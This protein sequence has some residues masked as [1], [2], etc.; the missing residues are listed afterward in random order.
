MRVSSTSECLSF[1]E[2][3]ALL[4]TSY[5]GCAIAQAVSRWLPTA[6]ARVRARVW[7]CGICGGQ[8]GT[9][10]GLLRVLRFPLPIFIPPIAPQSPSSI[11]WVLYNRPEVATV[12]S[13]LSPT[14]LI[15]FIQ[16][17]SQNFLSRLSPYADEIIGDHEGGFWHN[18]STTSQVFCNHQILKKQL[19]YSGT[20]HQLFID[21][22]KAYGSIRREILYNILIEFGIPMK[23]H[24]LI[25]IWLNKTYSKVSIGKHFSGMFPI[26]NNLKQGDA[27]MS[28][29]F[30]FAS[31][32]TIREVQE[33]QVGLKLN[34]TY[35]CW[36]CKPV[37]RRGRI[38]P[39]WPCES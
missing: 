23:L 39:P 7:S 6:V 5:K 34:W 38:P 18:R 24:R 10:A 26:K 37:W 1:S 14:P 12:P 22:K 4:S 36:G 13:G 29:L 20:V 33:N 25:K 8:S 2:V 21:F 28:V 9:G 30:N 27:L 3:F 17:F 16:T 31:E 15:N 11:I 19:E 32:Y 35:L